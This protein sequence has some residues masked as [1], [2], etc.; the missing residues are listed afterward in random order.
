MLGDLKIVI[1]KDWHKYK[2]YKY[3]VIQLYVTFFDLYK[4]HASLKFYQ[5]KSY[6]KNISNKKEYMCCT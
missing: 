5:E 6:E 3:Q 1:S 4:Y 2:K